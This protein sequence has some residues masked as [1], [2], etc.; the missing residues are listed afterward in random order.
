MTILKIPRTLA[1]S[2]GEILLL[3]II[4]CVTSHSGRG[5]LFPFTALSYTVNTLLF[6]LFV[7]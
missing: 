7:F 4:T 3:D 1:H 2:Q 6:V 5:I